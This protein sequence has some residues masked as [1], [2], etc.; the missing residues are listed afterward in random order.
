MGYDPRDH[1]PLTW[2]DAT[3]SF[4][5]GADT[6]RAYLDRCL[7][8]ITERE[9]GVLAWVELNEAG[10]RTAADAATARWKAGAPLSPI[11]GMPI[12]IKD[13]LETKDMPTRQ[14]CVAYRDNFPRRDNAAVAAL[15]AAGAVILGKTVTTELGASEPGPTR[16]PF[17]ATRT[18]GGSSSGS[19]AAVAAR[20]IPA[21]IGS[22]VGGSII[23]P[24]SYCGNVALKPTQGAIN[25]GERQATSMSTHG[26]HA[27]CIEDMWQVA[28][29]IS[30]RAGGDPGRLSLKGPDAPPAA[31]R[32]RSLIVLEGEGWTS[33][34]AP[35]RSAFETLMEQLAG[36]GIRIMRRGDHA[37]IETLETRL[38]DARAMANSITGWEGRWSLRGLVDNHPDGV[39]D[40]AKRRLVTAEAMSVVGYEARL[41]ERAD[42]QAAHARIAPLADAVIMLSSPGPAPVWAGDVPGQPVNPR[43]TGDITFN[44]P[45]S[46]LF[47]PAVTMPLLAVGG[48]PLGVQVMGQQGQDAEMTALAR[49]LLAEAQPVVV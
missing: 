3:G 4:A 24:A 27:G 49:W 34:D 36:L 25:R 15:R 43:P 39:S 2:H 13:L 47:A 30:K 46:A 16:N 23:R 48:L 26:V 45:S 9:P 44:A 11:D 38:A 28:I 35:S 40:R 22:Q 41:A 14:G 33:L 10:A 32:P 20:M 5:T 17:D 29:E 8:T 18:P 6:P 21:A 1:H 31:R 37:A 12:G 42:A 7:A 19:A